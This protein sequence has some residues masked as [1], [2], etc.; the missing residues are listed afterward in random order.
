[1]AT[2]R[3]T[4]LVR[5]VGEHLVAAKLGR[6]GFYATPFAGNVPDFDLVVADRRG[7]SLLVQVKAI[8]GGSWQF[9]DARSYID[10]ELVGN[11]QSV[12]GV[13]E[14]ENPEII[15]VL[16]MLNEETSDEYYVL[17]LRELQEKI[18]F[19]YSENLLKK[20][21]V[22]PRNPASMH[23][24]LWSKELVEFRDKWEKITGRFGA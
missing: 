11:V 10:V 24:A 9:G 23:C 21:G 17:T 12:R 3:T 14:L 5:Q 22:R 2:G 6:L 7:R 13:R 15:F 20:G 1:M 16:V 4:Q 19:H 18:R 8:A